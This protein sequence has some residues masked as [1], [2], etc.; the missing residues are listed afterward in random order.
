MAIEKPEIKNL[1][2]IFTISSLKIPYYQRPYIWGEKSVT[3][4]Y[5]DIYKAY[6]SNQNEYRLGTIILHNDKNK[7][8]FN[9]VDGQQRLISLAL[10]LSVLGE[11]TSLLDEEVNNII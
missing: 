2:D 9:I 8:E 1:N 4:L 10:L 5:N 6:K 7:N 3:I 11:S